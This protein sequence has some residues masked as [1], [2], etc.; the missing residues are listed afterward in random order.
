MANLKNTTIN[1]TGFLTLAAGTTAQRPVSPTA[2]MIR[3]NTTWNITEYY[4]GSNW[5]DL[6]SNYIA[7]DGSTAALAAESATAIKYLTGTTTNGTYWINLPTVGATQIFC[8][9]DNAFAGGGW[10]MALKANT[11]TTFNYSATY[12]TTNNTLNPTDT[13]QNAGDAKFHSFNYFQAVDI[14]ARWPDITA[15]GSIPGVGAW[16]WL[17]SGFN[18]GARINLLDF[19]NNTTSPMYAGGSGMFLNDAITFN[20]WASGVFSSQVDIRFYGFNYINNPTYGVSGKVRWGFGWN[21]NGEG[22]YPGISGPYDGS[23]DVSGGIGM[24]ASFGSYSAGDRINCC[25]NTTGIN[26]SARVEIYVR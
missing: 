2:G 3:Y 11:G 21:E 19:F 15:G 6:S 24:D 25:Q 13:T 14:M 7:A 1:D 4:N 9:M 22:L 12:W 17:E 5:R 10:M 26:R 16:T 23:N 8:I 20:G 18:G